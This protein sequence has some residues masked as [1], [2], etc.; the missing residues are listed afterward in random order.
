VNNSS[1][2]DGLL[3]ESE[4]TVKRVL[5]VTKGPTHPEYSARRALVHSLQQMDNLSF[6]EVPSLDRLPKDFVD[7][8]AMVLYFHDNQISKEALSSFERYVS[9]GGGVLAVHSA[10]ASFM[11]EEVYFNILGG[12]FN[13][14]GP[15]SRFEIFPVSDSDVF[16]GI[17]SFSVEDELYLHEINAEITVHFTAKNDNDPVPVV[18]TKR[19]GNGRVCYASPG[20]RHETMCH[21]EYQT[22]LMQGLQWVVRSEINA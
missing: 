4:T 14:H 16:K 11:A 19:Y 15:I 22:L 7:Y 2:H 1:E 12:R 17:P 3:Q 18:W 13:E 9:E 10:T 21:P 8:D 6:T 20:H 5:L